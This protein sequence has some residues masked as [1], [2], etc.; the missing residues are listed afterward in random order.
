[1]LV[2]GLAAGLGLELVLEAQRQVLR[3]VLRQVRGA[4]RVVAAQ[5]L[6]PQVPERRLLLRVPAPLLERSPVPPR[7]AR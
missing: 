1:M 4:V 5:L 6:G 2:L 3:Q 7:R